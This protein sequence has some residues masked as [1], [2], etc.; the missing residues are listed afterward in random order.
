MSTMETLSET[1]SM[2]VLNGSLGMCP[3]ESW[4]TA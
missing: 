3:T 2:T 4:F 1:L